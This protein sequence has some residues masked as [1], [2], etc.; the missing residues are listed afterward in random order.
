[1]PEKKSTDEN[2]AQDLSIAALLFLLGSKIDVVSSLI[3]EL[4]SHFLPRLDGKEHA[5][6]HAIEF[7][8]LIFCISC[9]SVVIVRFLTT[10][11]NPKDNSIIIAGVMIGILAAMLQILDLT[12]VK[13]DFPFVNLLRAVFFILM[14]LFLVWLPC[15]LYTSDAADE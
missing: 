12:F 9:F 6:E 10:K 8:L 11:N 3:Y 13:G 15:L 1:M 5:P 2:V 7:S 4:Y 14:I